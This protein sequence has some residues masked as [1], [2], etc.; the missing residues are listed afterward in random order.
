VNHPDP[1]PPDQ[2]LVEH[3]GP[4]G[5]LIRVQAD[6]LIPVLE[7][8]RWIPAPKAHSIRVPAARSIPGPEAAR[9][10]QGPA[11]RSTQ[12]P[13]DRSTRVPVVPSIPEVADPTIQAGEAPWTHL[14]DRRSLLIQRHTNRLIRAQLRHPSQHR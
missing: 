8:A 14:G 3:Q 6:R 10:T 4:E 12:G 11:A 7:E 5:P 9:S 1:D 2:V 13:E